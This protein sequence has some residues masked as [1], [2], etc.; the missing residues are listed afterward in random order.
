M[1]YFFKTSLLVIPILF[2]L[3]I[4]TSFSQEKDVIKKIIIDPNSNKR[5]LI[6]S[7]ENNDEKIK[8]IPPKSVTE[9]E[10]KKKDLDKEIKAIRKAQE[11]KR[12]AQEKKRNEEIEAARKA[13]EKKRRALEE[14]R[15]KEIEDARKAEKQK[16]QKELE[17]AKKADYKLS[18]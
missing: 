9:S 2:L 14:K 3:S 16:K 10:S 17:A 5:L 1:N 12:K 7:I 15:K 13:Q 8:L 4:K 11:E 18:N 6:P